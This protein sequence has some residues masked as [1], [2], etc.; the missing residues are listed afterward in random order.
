MKDTHVVKKPYFTLPYVYLYSLLIAAADTFFSRNSDLD[1]F[2]FETFCMRTLVIFTFWLIIRLVAERA[3]QKG[4][5]YIKYMLLAVA[6]VPSVLIV[7]AY[8]L[9]YLIN[10]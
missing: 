9:Q 5:S 1:P 10:S 8:A 6:I 7:I 3:E 2:N 4:R